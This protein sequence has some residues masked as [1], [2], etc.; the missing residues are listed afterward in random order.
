M[1]SLVWTISDHLSKYSLVVFPPDSSSFVVWYC[2]TSNSFGCPDSQIQLHATLSAAKLRRLWKAA[3][4]QTTKE[5]NPA[6]IPNSIKTHD[7]FAS[8]L[9]HSD[10]SSCTASQ[11]EAGHDWIQTLIMA[12]S[13]LWRVSVDFKNESI[14]YSM[15]PPAT[16][17]EKEET[18]KLSFNQ[19][20]PSHVLW[21]SLPDC[22]DHRRWDASTHEKHH[23]AM[24]FLGLD[25]VRQVSP[26]LA[27]ASLYSSLWY[28]SGICQKPLLR[29]RMAMETHSN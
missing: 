2:S 21:H 28:C 7:K 14:V 11:F 6:S 18:P 27:S 9:Q 8:S 4:D 5:K 19:E 13:G 15:L 10:Q 22:K 3:L 23:Q 12:F 17:Y 16:V 29:L 1:A 20:T 25:S 26:K 24:Y